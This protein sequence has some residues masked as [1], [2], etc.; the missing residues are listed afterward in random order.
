MC[1]SWSV[2]SAY[3]VLLELCP[4]ISQ[5]RPRLLQ[6]F[7]ILWISS[8]FLIWSL[9]QR[10]MLWSLLDGKWS[11]A[12]LLVLISYF[13]SPPQEHWE[14]LALLHA[15]QLRQFWRDG[16]N[17]KH[18]LYPNMPNPSSSVMASPCWPAG[19]LWSGNEG[20]G[21]L[22]FHTPAPSIWDVSYSSIVTRQSFLFKQF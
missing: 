20:S 11:M 3:Q 19:S 7:Q 18:S 22:C 4:Q 16:S 2:L 12:T 13:L 14:I 21:S 5:P 9:P 8:T 17:L 10:A 1:N 6:V 15:T